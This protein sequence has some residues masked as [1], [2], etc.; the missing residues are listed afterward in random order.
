VGEVGSSFIRTIGGN[1]ECLQAGGNVLVLEG[2]GHK[3]L[4]QFEG[5]YLLDL[6]GQDMIFLGQNQCGASLSQALAVA[7]VCVAQNQQNEASS[8]A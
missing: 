3:K 1:S 2:L 5:T 7:G 8:A 4:D 6:I